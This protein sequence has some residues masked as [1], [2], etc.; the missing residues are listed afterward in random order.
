MAGLP[1]SLFGRI[2]LILVGGLIAVQLMTTALHIGERDSLVVR[3]GHQP[4]GA[5]ERHARRAG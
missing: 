3:I 2:T 5:R 1:K 4:G